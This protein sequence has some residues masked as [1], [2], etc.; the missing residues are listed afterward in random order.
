[1]KVITIGRGEDNQIVLE[2]NQ[3]MISR[4]HATLRIYETGKMEIIST[5]SNGTFVNGFR[6]KSNIPYKV[7]RKDVISFAHI[8]QLD[9][10]TIP[11]PFKPI[12]IGI[13]GF[14]IIIFTITAIWLWS[15]RTNKY[16]D[17]TPYKTDVKSNNDSQTPEEDKQEKPNVVS[18]KEE[19]K[20]KESQVNPTKKI[21]TTKNK[22]KEEKPKK[23]NKENNREDNEE[24]GSE[25]LPI[26]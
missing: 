5:G 2:D 12:R 9:W 24:A 14:F 15:Q 20:P 8:R 13:I 18:I 19:T 23:E 16:I 21:P 25:F 7:T 22:K 1:M 10:A 6:I 17:S 11:D 3:D 26:L 4:Q